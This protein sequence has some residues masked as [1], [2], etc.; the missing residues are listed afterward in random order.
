MDE[1]RKMQLIE[2]DI[3]WEVVSL[4]DENGIRYYLADG[5]ALGAVRHRGFIPWDDDID[6]MVPRA[7][8]ERLL[9]ILD[10]NLPP[11]LRLFHYKKQE[12]CLFFQAK[13]IDLRYE[14]DRH[15]FSQ[16]KRL[17]IWIDI[18]P[19]DGMQTERGLRFLW[20]KA[21]IRGRRFIALA[22]RMQYHG[23]SPAATRSRVSKT[24]FFLDSLLHFSRRMDLKKHMRR[25]EK[26]L[27]E[28]SMDAAPYYLNYLG[29]Y[30]FREC[31]PV[32]ELDEGCPMPF[33]GQSY[34][35]PA[36]YDAYLRRIYGEYEKL[37]PEAERKNKHK[38]ERIIE[39]GE[40]AT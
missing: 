39:K 37:P 27:S 30:R 15:V 13:V 12:E 16:Q 14:I 36:Q 40:A 6:I 38:I 23:D 10:E 28:V 3:L 20:R 11:H 5:T 33:E 25:L 35:I 26:I 2:T 31:G 32:A 18:F 7:D 4:C 24:M 22:A 8:Y 19:L 17:N 9:T 29:A 21:R 1:L 34:R